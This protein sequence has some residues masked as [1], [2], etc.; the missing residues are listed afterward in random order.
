VGRLEAGDPG[1]RALHGG[2][3]VTPARLGWEHRRP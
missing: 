1:V 2:L 3:D